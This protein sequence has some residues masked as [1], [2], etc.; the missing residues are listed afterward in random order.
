LKQG[1]NQFTGD[2]LNYDHLN[3]VV[4]MQ[5]RVHGVIQAHH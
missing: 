5:G 1:K 4:E 3:S 2:S